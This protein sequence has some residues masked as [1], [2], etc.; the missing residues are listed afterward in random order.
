MS[1]IATL[2]DYDKRFETIMKQSSMILVLYSL[3]TSTMLRSILSRYLHKGTAKVWGEI[4]RIFL[5][6]FGK[7][8]YVCLNFS[9]ESL[10][11][12]VFFVADELFDVRKGVSVSQIVAKI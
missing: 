1:V 9:K 6:K 8:D 7:H 3:A 2:H 10:S 12:E 11:S 4:R 5:A